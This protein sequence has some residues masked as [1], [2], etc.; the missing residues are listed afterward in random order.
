MLVMRALL[1]SLAATRSVMNALMHTQCLYAKFRW[2]ISEC[3]SLLHCPVQVRQEPDFRVTLD[4][5]T[6]KVEAIDYTP[7]NEQDLLTPYEPTEPR[8]ILVLQNS[9]RSQQSQH[10]TSW[11]GSASS[12]AQFIALAWKLGKPPINSH[13]GIFKQ[14]ICLR[15]FTS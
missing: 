13:Q 9:C 10:L 3:R 5:P 8:G 11:R 14:R 15:S 12:K 1:A 2:S 4:H 6:L 7:K